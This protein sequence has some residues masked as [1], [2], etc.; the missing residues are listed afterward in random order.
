MADNP[1]ESFAF[2]AFDFDDTPDFQDLPDWSLYVHD[3]NYRVSDSVLDAVPLDHLTP[4]QSKEFR[5][6]L[7]EFA[8]IFAEDGNA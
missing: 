2:L 4:S 8:D 7:E 3:P 1:D 5:E 6:L